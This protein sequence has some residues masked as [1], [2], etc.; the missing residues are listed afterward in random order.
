[1]SETPKAPGR[2]AIDAEWTELLAYLADAEWRP[3]PTEDRMSDP[4]TPPATPD[5]VNHPPHYTTGRIE[6]LDFIEDQR[7]GYLEGQVIKYLSRAPHKGA[8]LEDLK[9]ARFYLARRIAQLEQTEPS[10]G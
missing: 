3:L 9:K 4:R 6:V 7:F 2:D 8:Q 10:N 5:M 1:M